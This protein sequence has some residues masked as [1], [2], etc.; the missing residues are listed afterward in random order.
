M[1][2]ERLRARQEEQ[3]LRA[4]K[5]VEIDAQ[6]ALKKE[7]YEAERLRRSEEKKTMADQDLEQE[8]LLD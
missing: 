6:R 1:Q 5:K 8:A 2:A 3:E 4:L 7:K